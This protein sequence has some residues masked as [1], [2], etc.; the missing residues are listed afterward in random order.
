MERSIFWCDIAET[1]STLSSAITGNVSVQDFVP[2]VAGV[3]S[4]SVSGAMRNLTLLVYGQVGGV[5]A[6]DTL[7]LHNLATQFVAEFRSEYYCQNSPAYRKS[8][9]L[10]LHWLMMHPSVIKD[11]IELQ[12]I[13]KYVY[14]ESTQ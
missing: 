3:D 10:V 11:N 14:S 13:V 2:R 5:I 9:L 4:T 6:N 1:S 8:A 12:T 7:A